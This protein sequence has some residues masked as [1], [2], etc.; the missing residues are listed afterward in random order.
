M[1]TLIC[2]ST[3]DYLNSIFINITFICV[4]SFIQLKIYSIY[5]TNSCKIFSIFGNVFEHWCDPTMAFQQ[6]LVKIKLENND[7]K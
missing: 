3:N 4:F 7:L 2:L 1:Q 5:L 6:S